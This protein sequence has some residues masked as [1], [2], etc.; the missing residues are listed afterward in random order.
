MSLIENY[1]SAA[2]EHMTG[3]AG[4]DGI[5]HRAAGPKLLDE[6]YR[7]R[8]VTPHVRLPTGHS[9]ILFSYNLSNFTHYIINTAGPVYNSYAAEQCEM[10][11]LKCYET[12]IA[13]A[14]LYDLKSIA[15]P[16]ISC[17][18]FGYVRK[19]FLIILLE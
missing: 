11:L 10:D 17:G 7:H 9:R 16:A 14:N 5:I 19:S 2:N 6:C 3:G 12:S 4:V 1:L 18:I 8:E 15:F 13:L